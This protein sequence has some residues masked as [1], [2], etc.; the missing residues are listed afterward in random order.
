MIVRD[1]AVGVVA[2]T[3][4]GEREFAD[5]ERA[6]LE[7]LVR[8][9][10]AAIDRAQV[11]AAALRRQDHLAL[12]ADSSSILAARGDDLVEALRAV[13]RRVVPVLADMCA[14]FLVDSGTGRLVAWAANDP[15]AHTTA[16]GLGDEYRLDAAKSHRLKPAIQTNTIVLW[17]DAQSFADHIGAPD[18]LR[19]AMLDL[20]IGPGTLVPLVARGRAVGLLA[21]ANRAGRAPQADETVL[22]QTLG[23]RMAVLID[24][25]RL[26]A[27]RTEI[28][29]G[30]QAALLPPTLPQI[31]G[32][33]I[34]AR[35]RA[36]GDGLDVGGDF[37]DVLALDADRWLFVIGDVTGHGVRAAAVTGLLRHTIAGAA[38]LGT[39]LEEILVHANSVLGSR[40]P[41]SGTFATVALIALDRRE[42]ALDVAC[43][44]HPPPLLKRVG[45]Q[46]QEVCANGRILGFFEHLDVEVD[47]TQLEPGDIVLA[48]TDGVT[49]RHDDT[50]WFGP[51]EL[52]DLISTCTARTADDLASTVAH[53]V[54]EGFAEPPADDIA[55]LVLRRTD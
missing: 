39:S 18:S 1:R 17:E 22:A 3:F 33:E 13:A 42:W 9:C 10:A 28:S 21:L 8:H 27:Q 37:Y 49:E 53:A 32:L 47:R 44:G 48:Y 38:R 34:A 30:L 40:Q 15:D 50:S 25:A 43:A 20:G 31:S 36:A 12:I 7:S 52:Q 46:V 14:V 16:T 54:V 4:D 23:Q 29:Q 35:Y 45:G 26:L 19:A 41:D 11:H 51:A 24:N 2:F 55:V 6:F 5:E